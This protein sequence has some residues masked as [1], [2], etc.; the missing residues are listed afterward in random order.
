MKIFLTALLLSAVVCVFAQD[1][2]EATSLSSDYDSLREHYIKSYPD[3][4]FIWPV[5]KQR[6]QDFELKSLANGK[7]RLNYKS[8]KP[9][10]LG[11]GLYLFDVA[12]ELTFAVPLNEKRRAIYGES[13]SRDLQINALGEKFG[14]DAY[15]QKYKGFY[16][17]DPNVKMLPN[18][19]YSQRAD[20]E[21]SNIG[22]NGSY[23]F[24]NKKFSFRSAY[25]YAERQLRSNGSFILFSS[26]SAF[27]VSGDSAIIADDDASKFG[28]NANIKIIKATTLGIA[29]GYTYS[30]IY[31]GFFL[32]GTLAIGP[33]HNWLFNQAEGGSTQNDI[34][35]STFVAARI[36][37][38]YNGDH[39]FGGLGFVNQSR[40]A[41]FET[42]Q[43]SSTTTTFKILIGYRF[44]EF[45]ILKKRLV[46]IAKDLLK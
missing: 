30:L 35:F 2:I 28:S 7:D 9:Y 43:F 42:I 36:G 21:T 20:I 18:Q 1:D 10:A 8:N 25:T 45:G 33:A 38:G 27:K 22:M 31:K 6:A 11:V 44:R 32:N 14:V 16:I 34:K 41:K 23:V 26:L 46:D 12:L 37:L 4:F 19:P 15:F 24:N 5:L 39:F 3:H 17:T 29:P 40:S 13:K